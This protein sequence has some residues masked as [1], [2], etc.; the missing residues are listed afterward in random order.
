M[1]EDLAMKATSPLLALA[2]LAMSACDRD[3]PELYPPDR[4]AAFAQPITGKAAAGGKEA[5]SNPPKES[6]KP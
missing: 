1:L 5:P 6:A 4:D 2:S 3:T